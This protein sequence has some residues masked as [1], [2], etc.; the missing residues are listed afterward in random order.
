[1]ALAAAQRG[2]WVRTSRMES[3]ENASDG[4]LVARTRA[5]ERGAYGELVRRHQA[6]VYNIAYRLVGERETARDLAQ[7]T[8]VRAFSALA[9]FDATRPFA[10]WIHRIATNTALNWLERQHVPTVSLERDDTEPARAIPDESNDPARALLVQE[11]NAHVRRALIALPP[12]QRAVIELRH[13]QDLP[14]EEIA[15]TL[16]IPLS[17]VK[18]DL[19]RARQHLRKLLAG[20]R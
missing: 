11:Q 5:G 9:S 3:F 4:E 10:P 7:E 19:F 12:R 16:G 20:E 15:T 2:N 8:F 6:T 18:S 1:M 14:Y 13:F 17:D